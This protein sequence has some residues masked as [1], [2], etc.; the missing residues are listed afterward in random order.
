M[1]T[2]NKTTVYPWPDLNPLRIRATVDE[3][4]LE[5]M[6]K[7]MQDHYQRESYAWEEIPLLAKHLEENGIV[8]L[9]LD[10]WIDLMPLLPEDFYDE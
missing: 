6:K 4:L 8:K 9:R 3:G 1:T 7:A 5:A 2:D 10:P